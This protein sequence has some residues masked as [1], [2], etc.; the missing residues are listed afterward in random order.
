M[1]N[2]E[3]ALGHDI[4][5]TEVP[6]YHAGASSYNKITTPDGTRLFH[7]INDVFGLTV[8]KNAL[9]AAQIGRAQQARDVIYERQAGQTA[10][11]RRHHAK[12]K[13]SNGGLEVS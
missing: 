3:H 12:Q 5:S 10:A 11:L 9:R 2:I 6:G 8:D 13:T 7:H 4:G 1:G